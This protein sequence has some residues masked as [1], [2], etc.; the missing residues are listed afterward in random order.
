[1]RIVFKI[2]N[3]RTWYRF[4]NIGVRGTDEFFAFSEFVNIKRFETCLNRIWVW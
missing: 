1:M 3:H 2:E 4:G